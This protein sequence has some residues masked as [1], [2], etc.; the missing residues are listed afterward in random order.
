MKKDIDWKKVNE[1]K[2]AAQARQR[3]KQLAKQADPAYRAAKIEKQRERA[4][5]QFQNDKDKLDRERSNPTPL[6]DEENERRKEKI[7]ERYRKEKARRSSPEYIEAQR[8]KAKAAAERK[9]QKELADNDPKV[10]NLDAKRKSSKSG[11]G[12]TGR[13]PTALEKALMDEIGKLPCI[14]CYEKGQVYLGE[15]AASYISLH[16]V[17]GRTKPLAHAKVLPLCQYHHDQPPPADAPDW[18]FPLHGSG[19]KVWE[20]E[21]GTQDALL[22]LVYDIIGYYRPWLLEGELTIGHLKKKQD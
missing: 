22:E 2:R 9:R 10:S 18:L 15:D 1:K 17:E 21:N 6:S 8:E 12:L 14:C 20:E 11:I 19:R 16:H 3:A 4:Q 7:R 5:R 13:T